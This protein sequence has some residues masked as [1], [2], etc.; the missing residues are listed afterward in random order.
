MSDAIFEVITDHL[1]SPLDVVNIAD[2][3]DVLRDASYDEWGEVTSS[4]S[5]TSASPIPFGFAGACTTTISRAD[6]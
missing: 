4:T 2:P 6:F 5:G 1:C 3:S